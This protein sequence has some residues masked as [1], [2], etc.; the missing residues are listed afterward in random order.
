MSTLHLLWDSSS[1]WGL[2]AARA[3]SAFNIPHRIVRG[4][5]IARGILE[6]EKPAILLV[7]GGSAK[8]KSLAL[9]EEGRLAIRSFVDQGGHY[10]GICG[11][12]GLALSWGNKKKYKSLALCPWKRGR[13]DDPMQHFMSGH[14]SVK[15]PGLNGLGAEPAQESLSL[16]DKADP[17]NVNAFPQE[18]I[19]KFPTGKIPE[20]LLPVWWPSRFA[21]DDSKEVVVLARYAKPGPDF[22]LTDLPIASLP[23]YIFESWHNLYG[24]SLSPTFLEGQPCVIHGKFG[25]G[26]YTLSYSHLETPDSP[27]ANAWLAHLFRKLAGINPERDITPPWDIEKDPV[28]WHDPALEDVEKKVAA[29]VKVGL[30]HGIFF[31]RNEWLFGWRSGIPGSNLN[32]LLATIRVIRR[33]PPC[34]ESLKNWESIKD[35][36]TKYVAL[37]HQAGVDYLLAE[38][39]AQTIA[40]NSPESV[41]QHALIDQRNT[42][43]GPPMQ[44]GGFFNALMEPLE[45]LVFIQL[46]GKKV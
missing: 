30:D 14:I 11:G 6:K 31:Q 36:I 17:C 34:A 27:F 18:L 16:N 46:R 35:H 21:P 22:W 23:S 40:K 37:F 41:P 10:I 26:T 15:I 33:T 5:E 29:V 3:M 8:G 44:P 7:P 4:S 12:A 13:F 39:L 43:F 38:R 45:E 2:L 42:L 9:G 32:C 24:F 19:P 1:L 28:L 25:S 20:E